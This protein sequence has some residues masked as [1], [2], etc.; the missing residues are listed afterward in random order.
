MKIGILGAG[1]IGGVM[2]DTV[3]AM[4]KAEIYAVAAR[5]LSRAQEFAE[6]YGIHKA[7]GSYE[8]MVADPEVELVYIATPHSHHYEHARL[9]L[10]HG[11]AVLCEKAFTQN[12]KEAKAILELAKTKNLL[13]TEAMWTRYMPM[14]KTLAELLKSGVIG[15]IT[16]LYASL[17][18]ALAHIERMQ[19]PSLAG[20][21]LLDLGIYPLNFAAMV[22][23]SQIQSVTSTAVL[24]KKGVDAS[25]SITLIYEDGK[26]AVLHSNFKAA[27]DR[28][29]MIYG[30]EGYIEIVNINNYEE[31]RVYDNTHRLLAAYPAPE[32]IS[33]YEYEIEACIEALEHGWT[34]CP[35]MPHRETLRMMELMDELRAKWGVRYP[36]E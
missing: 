33:G 22:F 11:K 21:A 34:E 15:E 25:N 23:G 35:A 26:M 7:Y 19:E 2:A 32:H 8:E 12:A 20:G 24:T 3:N 16:S 30:S 4:E 29:G 18:Y 28:R 9:C 31:F 1:H 5:E 17:G 6:K 13:I 10:E 36:G 27:T 14:R